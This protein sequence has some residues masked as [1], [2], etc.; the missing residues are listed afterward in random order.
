M[1]ASGSPLRLYQVPQRL[2]DGGKSNERKSVGALPKGSSVER[3]R[4]LLGMDAFC[5]FL[6][7]TDISFWPRNVGKLE[8]ETPKKKTGLG[9]G[10]KVRL[11]KLRLQENRWEEFHLEQL[12]MSQDRALRYPAAKCN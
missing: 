8:V 4:V 2:E 1:T 7:F 9:C 3:L 5:S 6:F 10:G 11:V 12:N